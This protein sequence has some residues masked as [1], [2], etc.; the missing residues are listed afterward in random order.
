MSRVD[1]LNF[2]GAEYFIYLQEDFVLYNNV[3]DYK[4]EILKNELNE[5]NYS[6]IRINKIW[7][8]K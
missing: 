3:A 6:F 1:A 4:I 7:G 5:S 2:F 8:I